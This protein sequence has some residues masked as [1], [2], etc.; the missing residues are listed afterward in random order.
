ME[1]SRKKSHADEKRLLAFVVSEEH[2]VLHVHVDKEGIDILMRS[3]ERLKKDLEKG[4]CEH[5]HLMSEEWG[6]WELSV[7]D[8]TNKEK[9]KPVHQVNIYGW[10]DEWAEKNGFDRN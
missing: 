1:D 9:G 5:E 10:T 3:L 6:G 8:Q 4:E 7:S 2:N